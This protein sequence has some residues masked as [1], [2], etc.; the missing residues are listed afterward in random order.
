MNT[1]PEPDPFSDQKLHNQNEPLRTNDIWEEIDQYIHNKQNWLAEIKDHFDLRTH[2]D[3]KTL[4]RIA[5]AKDYAM[6][7]ENIGTVKKVGDGVAI[8][9]GLKGCDGT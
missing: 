8:V 5:E 4:E 3:L 2:K 6:I 1:H 7:T 9:S